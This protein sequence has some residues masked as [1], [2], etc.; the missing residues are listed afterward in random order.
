MVVGSKKENNVFECTYHKFYYRISLNFIYITSSSFLCVS[1]SC[2]NCGTLNATTVT[3]SAF[4]N[5]YCGSLVSIL[6][7]QSAVLRHLFSYAEFELVFFIVWLEWDFL[8]VLRFQWIYESL[9]VKGSFSRKHYNNTFFL[10]FFFQGPVR[11][12]INHIC[13]VVVVT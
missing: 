8:Q 6:F 5:I 10:G 4:K 7:I 3:F 1:E 11:K 9:L 2:G 13:K 12:L